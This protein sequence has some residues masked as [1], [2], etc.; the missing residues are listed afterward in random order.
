MAMKLPVQISYRNMHKS[1]A[2]EEFVRKKAS[3]LDNVSPDIIRCAVIIEAP[4]KHHRQGNLFHVRVHLTFA[5]GELVVARDPELHHAH[6]DVF[7]AVRDA[8][9]A[10]RRDL[11][12]LV[13][14]RR[15]QVKLHE[16]ASRGRVTRLLPGEGPGSRYGFIETRDGRQVYFHEKSVFDGFDRLTRGTVVRFAEE[17]GEAGPQASTVRIVRA[18]ARAR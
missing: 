15:G 18:A 7:V 3:G 14:A 16:E 9:R 8:F 12:E 6:E 10:A 13:H 17:R 5:G 2:V 1:E 4:H 11:M